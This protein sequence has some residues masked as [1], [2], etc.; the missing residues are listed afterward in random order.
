M[1]DIR[2]DLTGA[3]SDPD[4]VRRAQIQMLKPLPKR[5]YTTVS[6][7]PAEDG[8]H[9]ILLDGRTVRTPAKQPL[10]VPT[11]ARRRIACRRMGCA[12][13][14]DRPGD[15]AGHPAG[16]YRDRWRR[17]RISAPSSTTS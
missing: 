10:T 2:D 12:E 5:F 14:K 15:H 11:P 3:L 1:P 8:G 16:Q 13:G 9:A 17:R 4:P 6:I 7:G